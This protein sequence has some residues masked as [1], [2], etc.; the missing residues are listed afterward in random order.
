MI[1][2]GFF[3]LQKVKSRRFLSLFRKGNWAQVLVIIFSLLIFSGVAVAVYFFSL[4]SFRFLGQYPESSQPIITYSLA[5]TFILTSLLILFSSVITGLGVLFQR[6]DNGL[7][8]SLPL[9]TGTIFESRFLDVITLSSW[10]LFVFALPQ[11]LGYSHALHLNLTT[12]LLALFGLLFLTLFVNLI[13]VVLSLLLSRFWGNMRN[14]YLGLAMI[15]SLPFLA[16]GLMRL[17]LPSQLTINLG[18]LSVEEISQLLKRQTIMSPYL[19]T[20]WLVNLVT[21]WEDDLI[22][23]ANNLTRLS[24]VC[25]ILTGIIY[26][27]RDKFYLKVVSKTAEGRFIAAPWDV[28][29]KKAQSFPYLLPGRIGALT[30]KDWLV[31]FRSPSQVT[32]IA[33]ILFLEIIY[34]LIIRRIPLTQIQQFF[35]NWYEG[36]LI[37]GNFL[38]TSYLAAVLAM[39]FFFPMISLEGHSSWV[40]WSAPLS[41]MSLFWQKAVSSFLILLIWLE[42]ATFL[43]VKILE[44]G[45]SWQGSLLLLNLP[46]ALCLTIITLGIG[47]ISPN[48]W[49]KNPEKLSTSPGGLA[50]TFLSLVYISFLAG[51][52]LSQKGRINLITQGSTWLLSLLLIAPIIFGVSRQIKKYEA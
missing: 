13:G 14:K 17:L 48:F 32:Q 5:A 8:F 41:R 36:Y 38:F 19:P 6:N 2:P 50:A 24:F 7:V 51:L 15:I 4:G 16:W 49:E 29:P 23:A 43:S 1:D 28:S 42:A 26:F 33:F 37:F 20:T 35:P 22:A 18:A 39:R 45:F 44:P 31:I 12:M 30:E 46:L 11:I 9:Q 3:T 10:P 21:L 27:L 40:I 34:L 52:I 25:V 47:A